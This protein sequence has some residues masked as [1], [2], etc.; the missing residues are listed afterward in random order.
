MLLA[1]FCLYF[2]IS[3]FLQQA[4]AQIDQSS[5]M[6]LQKTG[7]ESGENTDQKNGSSN[8]VNKFYQ[9]ETYQTKKIVKTVKNINPPQNS[10]FEKVTTDK[11]DNYAQ[12]KMT[13]NTSHR[14]K[15]NI[16]ENL[17]KMVYP[18]RLQGL[19]VKEQPTVF[20]EKKIKRKTANAEK[21]N[22]TNLDVKN[23]SVDSDEQ[24]DTTDENKNDEALDLN[25]STDFMNLMSGKEASQVENYK[26]KLHPDDNRINR[27]EVGIA[28][29]AVSNRSK[30]NYYYR[31]YSTFSPALQVDGKFWLSPFFG[32]GGSYLTSVGAAIDGNQESK[33]SAHHEWE[34]IS[35]NMRKYFG[36]YRKSPSITFGLVYSE[37]KLSVPSDD[38]S[39]IQ[40]KSAGLGLHLSTRLPLT[41]IYAQSF[42]LQAIP[43]VQ[44]TELSTGISAS[45]GNDPTSMK[46]S[47]DTGGEIKFKRQ[48]LMTWKLLYSLENNKFDG[49]ADKIDPKSN[50]KPQGVSVENSFVLFSIGYT[51]GQ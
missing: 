18:E 39:R 19:A 30:S 22:E 28:T 27:I 43:R 32:L 3:T 24:N 17:E 44:N 45:S 38:T 10:E 4:W 8:H 6:L 33:I 42:G 5:L 20:V 41:R 16:D 21:Q 25:F 11:T 34:E 7:Q 31:D 51:W 12:K 13:S 48:S 36:I 14:N 35:L 2:F 50:I 40:T 29:G 47:I 46:F 26:Q 49:Q 9:S 37:Y 15:K 1:R 23:A